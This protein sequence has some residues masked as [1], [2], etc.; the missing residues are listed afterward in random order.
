L[1]TRRY[2]KMA[3]QKKKI[4]AK[5]V[6]KS[7]H[8][9]DH[10]V[11]YWLYKTT[12]KA[13]TMPK[14]TPGDHHKNICFSGLVGKIRNRKK[15]PNRLLYH[16]EDD[17]SIGPKL[18]LK[19]KR[20]FVKISRK[21]GLLPSYVKYEWIG[22][23]KMKLVLDITDLSPS[24]LYAYLCN[25]RYIREDPGFVRAVVYLIN[26]KKMDFHIAYALCH[27]ICLTFSAHT[28]LDYIS[29]YMEETDPNKI[30]IDV[31]YMAAI[32]RYLKDPKKYDKRSVYDGGSF[33]CQDSI[34]RACKVPGS[35][36]ATKFFTKKLAAAI[37]G[38]DQKLRAFI[39][40]A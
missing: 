14:N 9:N 5:K 40:G 24:L 1:P 17:K 12:K 30:E 27:R 23:E 16:M 33:D 3:A 31:K 19:E 11:D 21:H 28:V 20:E 29:Q 22:K 7:K 2:G 35:V 18:T 4:D 36:D 37:R 38:S 10:D 15:K 32:Y 39:K 8:T 26:D 13:T 34:E 6:T 25:F